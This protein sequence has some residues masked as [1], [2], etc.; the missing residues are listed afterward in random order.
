MT[1][2]IFIRI[3]AL[4]LGFAMAGVGMYASFIAYANSGYLAVA[5]PLVALAAAL[6]PG[7]AERA[8]HDRQHLRALTLM[9]VWLPCFAM[10]VLNAIERNH[11]AKAGGEAERASYHTA[12]KR[13]ETELV[14]AKAAVRAATAAADKVRG[15]QGKACK[16]PCLNALASETAARARVKAAEKAL[17]IA[18]GSAVTEATLK[19]PD[20]LLPL[21]LEVASMFLIAC[22]FGLGREPAAVA[23]R[24]PVSEPALTPRQIA[25]R[26]GVE[27]RRKNKQLREKARKAGPKLAVSK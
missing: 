21:A 22:G 5:A 1:T 25:A 7:Y 24:I 6:I 26:K 23:A 16:T 14:E 10:V 4:V 18:D 8:W 27:T 20:W 19:A 2:L 15:L 11:A 13:A 17:Q 3:T 12:A 9:V